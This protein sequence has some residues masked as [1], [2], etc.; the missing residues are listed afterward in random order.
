MGKITVSFTAVSVSPPALGPT[1]CGQRHTWSRRHAR[2]QTNC[3]RVLL[4]GHAHVQLGLL[5]LCGVSIQRQ[6]RGKKL[7]TWTRFS[8]FGIP[9]TQCLSSRSAGVAQPAAAAA[10]RVKRAEMRARPRTSCSPTSFLP[11]RRVS[12][13]MQGAT[14]DA[15][16]HAV[17]FKAVVQKMFNVP[18]F[19]SLYMCHTCTP[20]AS[21]GRHKKPV[22]RN[23]SGQRR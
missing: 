2:E 12:E 13:E 19:P 7:T 10:S 18:C 8:S 20:S 1:C 14:S 17:P 11:A 21:T 16:S 3:E 4:D 9:C 6:R 23:G 22:Y 15:S 5:R